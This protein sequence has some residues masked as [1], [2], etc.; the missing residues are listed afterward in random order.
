MICYLRNCYSILK[1]VTKKGD[2][3]YNI[4]KYAQCECMSAIK[5]RFRIWCTV[6]S[7]TI[8]FSIW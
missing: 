6:G 2:Y 7:R 8:Y 1:A 5:I 4:T 3:S